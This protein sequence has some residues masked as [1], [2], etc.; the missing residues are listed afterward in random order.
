MNTPKHIALRWSA[1]PFTMNGYKH[2]APPEHF[3]AEQSSPKPF[4]C[5]ASLRFFRMTFDALKHRNIAQVDWMFERFVSL[6]TGFALSIAE[7]A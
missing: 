6:M 4:S 2:G 7:G 1:G 3:A 5:K